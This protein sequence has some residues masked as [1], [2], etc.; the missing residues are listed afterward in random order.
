MFYLIMQV[1]SFFVDFEVIG[2]SYIV[3][4]IIGS[5][6]ELFILGLRFS[7]VPEFAYAERFSIKGF[8]SFI[9]YYNLDY[10]DKYARGRG[11]LCGGPYTILVF[12]NWVILI[13]CICLSVPFL[14]YL[15]VVAVL[16]A[17]DHFFSVVLTAVFTVFF[18]LA[19]ALM[20]IICV[21]GVIQL[22]T[23]FPLFDLITMYFKALLYAK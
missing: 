3:I 6:V 21:A 14:F 1:A 4:T 13:I 8:F 22:V 17:P 15:P 5:A 23:G 19:A 11:A 16:Y 12:I 7:Y 9:F 2:I 20:A 10:V 18:F